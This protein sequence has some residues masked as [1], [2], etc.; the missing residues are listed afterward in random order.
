MSHSSK[1]VQKFSHFHQTDV[2]SLKQWHLPYVA[3]FANA[4]PVLDVGCGPMYFSDLLREIGVSSVGLDI[5]PSMVELATSR[6]HEAV[7]GD[8]RWLSSHPAEFGGVHISHVVEHLWGNELVELLE[9]AYRALKPSGLIVIRTPNW[10]VRYVREHL[11]W[12]DHTHKRPYPRQ[13][14]DRMLCDIG[15]VVIE[16]GCELLSMQDLYLIAAKPPAKELL[17]LR[18]QLAS[19]PQLSIVKRLKRRLRM[20]IRK[21][22]ELD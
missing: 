7:Q 10:Q 13:L 21:F 18:L 9:G 19:V 22:L 11:F 5:D 12:M 8:H 2:D 3:L 16:S 6:G 20:S 17:E 14:L 4:S 1:L 15:F